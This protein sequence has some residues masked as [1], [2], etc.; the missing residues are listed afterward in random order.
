MERRAED[1]ITRRRAGLME[2]REEHAK[3][4]WD[5]IFI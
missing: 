4:F 2:R 5:L 3:L 1:G